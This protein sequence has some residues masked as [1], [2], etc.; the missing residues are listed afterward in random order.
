MNDLK[1]VRST[2][3]KGFY[4][5][6]LNKIIDTYQLLALQT[7]GAKGKPQLYSNVLHDKSSSTIMVYNT[8]NALV[9]ENMSIK[10]IAQDDLHMT[11]EENLSINFKS[12]Q[13][14]IHKTELGL[15]SNTQT[16]TFSITAF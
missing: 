12:A 10:L 13:A 7:I 8:F 11:L 9:G 2:P 15:S 1:I 6:V 4:E 3:Q 16:L 14:N 5:I